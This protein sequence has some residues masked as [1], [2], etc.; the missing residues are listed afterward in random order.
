[1]QESRRAFQQQLIA[2]QARIKAVAM[3]VEKA[4]RGTDEYVDWVTKEN[5]IIREEKAIVEQLTMSEA[6]EKQYFSD[7]SS[8]LRASHEK[9]RARA[10]RT[11]YWGIMGSII[12]AAI[13]F[14][15]TTVNNYLRMKELRKLVTSSADA[16]KFYHDQTV[17]LGQTVNQQYG[18]MES[19]LDDIRQQLGQETNANFSNSSDLKQSSSAVQS[20]K[21]EEILS[22]LKVQE[23]NLEK[24][25]KE[26]K[27]L[28]VISKSGKDMGVENIVYV[29][30][31]V[32]GM[33]KDTEKSLEWKMKLQALGTVTLVYA[34]IAV[35]VPIVISFLKGAGSWWKTKCEPPHDKTNK[36]ACAPSKDSDQP[37][38]P[39]SLIILCCVLNG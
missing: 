14:I 35:T 23:S 25:F 26:V 15:G 18:K 30:P 19:F 29:G 31:E 37:G 11:K 16:S 17:M 36:M 7:L 10:E 13:A 39:P 33:L 38:H 1:M 34:A 20:G 28:I 9:E 21:L 32:E 2:V 12:G 24:E 4:T 3:E 22:N 5:Q 8:A 27:K 6:N